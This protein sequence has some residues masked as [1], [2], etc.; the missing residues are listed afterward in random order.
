MA[1]ELDATYGRSAISAYESLLAI[2][3]SLLTRNALKG[4]LSKLE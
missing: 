4:E 2:T 3:P 1:P